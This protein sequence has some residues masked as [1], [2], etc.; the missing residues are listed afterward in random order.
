M[1]LAILM[2]G[3]L[4]FSRGVP[5]GLGKDAKHNRVSN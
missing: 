4:G 5:I 3:D 2:K 1:I